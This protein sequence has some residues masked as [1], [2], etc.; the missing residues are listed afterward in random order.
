MDSKKEL[1]K[2]SADAAAGGNEK[3]EEEEM[4]SGNLLSFRQQRVNKWESSRGE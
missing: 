2:P 1:L 3:E 4:V